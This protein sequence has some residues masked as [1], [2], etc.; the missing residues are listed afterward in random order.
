M[1]WVH[2]IEDPVSE[3]EAVAIFEDKVVHAVKD[4]QSLVS[5]Q[6]ICFKKRGFGRPE[7]SSVFCALHVPLLKVRVDVVGLYRVV[8]TRSSR[9]GSAA[10]L[11][12]VLAAT[13]GDGT[14][15]TEMFLTTSAKVP[16]V[17]GDVITDRNAHL[18]YSDAKLGG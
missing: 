10:A 4:R 17:V 7:R 6:A 16:F 1:I 13:L 3:L 11:R 14:R 18:V 12:D 2:N 5:D 8:A 15:L 9:L